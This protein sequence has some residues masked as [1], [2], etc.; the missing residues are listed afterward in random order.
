MTVPT[1]KLVPDKEAESDHVKQTVPL[2]P[3]PQLIPPKPPDA[4]FLDSSVTGNRSN[5][6]SNQI[7]QKTSLQSKISKVDDEKMLGKSI[8]SPIAIQHFIP[9][10]QE[11]PPNNYGKCKH[12]STSN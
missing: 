8:D 3:R 12:K 5:A 10:P 2:P 11:A 1:Q 6:L 4:P 7:E 9:P